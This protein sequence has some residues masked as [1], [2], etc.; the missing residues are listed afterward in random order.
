MPTAKTAA[1]R[2]DPG[3]RYGGIS[4]AA[5]EKATGC[6][7]ERWLAHLD[8]AGA[9]RMTHK[10]I[11][12][13]IWDHHRAIGGWWCQMVT[14][15]YEQAR[16]KRAVHQTS[17][18]FTAG[19]SRVVHAPLAKLYAAFSDAR[20]RRKWLGASGYDVTSATARKYAR[21]A[22]KKP[23]CRVALY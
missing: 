15:G 4:D 20:Q 23:D 10:E 17:R 19:A 11:A 21:L 18:G 8:R 12:Q 14:V 16:G 7:W 22:W 6:G 2:S 9:E 3:H 13:W 1:K 5:V